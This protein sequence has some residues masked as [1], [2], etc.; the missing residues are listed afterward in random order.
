MS[1]ELLPAWARDDAFPLKPED[2]PY[3]CMDQQGKSESFESLSELK[4]FLAAGKSKLGWIWVPEHSRL[5]APEE[6][7]GFDK[8]LLKRRTILAS[9]DQDAAKRTLLI[10]GAAFLWALYAA[11][12]NQA[13]WSSPSLGL[14]TILLLV[15]GVKPWWESRQT[16]A[17]VS[18]KNVSVKDEIPEA[19]FELWLGMQKVWLTPIF[20]GLPLAVYVL[21]LFD[22][23][24]I[25]DA[26][27]IK[28][29]YH[30]GERW[31]LFTGPFLHGGLLHLV[32]NVSALWYLG[33]RA[34]ILA[35]WPHLALVFF[36]S[37]LGAGWAT[38][39]LM[40]ESNSVG[41]S[42][43][44]S[45]LLGF[46]LVFETLHR[47]LVPRSARLNLVGMLILMAVI[48]TLGFRFIDNAAHAGG[49]I[50]GAAYAAI[51]FP[52][53]SSPHRPEILG[54]DRIMGSGAL[55]LSIL[56]GLLAFIVIL[57]KK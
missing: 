20:L 3:G 11:V 30:A 27:L 48:G 26:G 24:A 39:A 52:K 35:R 12:Q 45:G 28:A 53:S 19:R 46:L 14:A 21:Q 16:L 34:E 57:V 4:D 56:S 29:A 13:V 40:P 7:D 33:R 44:V 5:I 6:Y 10:L 8:T 18:A 31:R 36:L 38:V 41:I 25:S 23:R 15:L 2:A 43:A 51:V 22:P 37:I 49:L 55:V 9:D 42:G 17:S 47:P 32:M 50:A 54:R 1:E